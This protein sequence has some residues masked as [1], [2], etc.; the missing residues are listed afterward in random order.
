MN[1]AFEFDEILKGLEDD[2]TQ[3]TLSLNEENKR[4]SYRKL[5]DFLQANDF[6]EILIDESNDEVTLS[7]NE[8]GKHFL[9]KGGFT[10]MYLIKQNKDN[11][12]EP[13]TNRKAI[14]NYISIILIVLIFLLI[15]YKFL[16]AKDPQL[17]QVP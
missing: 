3:I 12:K 8:K 14:L 10:K 17:D 5:I 7:L 13:K 6:C 16:I 9:S 15:L 1:E 11:E 2:D 4:S